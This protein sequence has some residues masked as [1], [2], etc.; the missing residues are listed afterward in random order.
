MSIRSVLMGCLLTFEENKKGAIAVG[1]FADMA[2]L[3]AD[4]LSVPDE[5][6]KEIK[7]VQTIVG[8]KLVYEA[9]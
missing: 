4:Y 2:V 9:P 5:Q 1:R 7:A 3:S 8:G 6:I